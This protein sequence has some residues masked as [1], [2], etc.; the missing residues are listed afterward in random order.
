M[1]LNTVIAQYRTG[2]QNLMHWLKEALKNEFLVIHEPFNETNDEYTTDF[3]LQDFT[4]LED[5]NYFIKELW[6]PGYSYDKIL[7]LSNKV[8][9]IYRENIHEHTIS[10]LYSTKKNKYHH[11]YTQKDVNDI[12]NQQEYEEFKNKVQLNKESLFEFA[13]KN[14]LPLISYEE[15]YYGNGIERFKEI[16]EFDSKI[17]FPFGEKY[18]TNSKKII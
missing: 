14:S 3:T 10:H 15:L 5:K 16:F 11:Q 2:G 4:W 7:N 9:C 17:P 18:F 1:L 8:I 12:F 13:S 6:Y